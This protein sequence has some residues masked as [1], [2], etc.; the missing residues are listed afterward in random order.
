MTFKRIILFL[1]I[2]I[3]FSCNKNG[4]ILPENTGKQNEVILVIEDKL[5]GGNKGKILKEVFEKE[6]EGIY[7][8]E[9]LFKLIQINSK[10]FSRF[11]KTHKNIIFVSSYKKDSYDKNKWAK[12]QTVVYLNSDSEETDF[13]KSCQETFNFL[14]RKEIEQIKNNYKK[15]YNENASLYIK[16]EFGFEIFLPTE[17]TISL[18]KEGLFVADF[19]SFNE[20]QDLLKYIIV[21]DFEP[22]DYELQEEIVIKTDSVLK[23]YILGSIEG[24]YAQI[25]SKIPLIEDNGIYKGLWFL[26]NG[27]MG[28]PIIIKT[29][30]VEDKI[31]VSLG[32]IFHP[33]ENKRNFVRT[34]EAIL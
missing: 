19:H 26:K 22:T 7:Q 32:I 18:K 1:L 14:D 27:F 2:I 17:Y 23:Q 12:D 20:K 33:N 10:E 16:E 29:R 28:G 5:W 24:S 8:S 4:K 30:H 21:Y 25:E 34:F 3:L 6:I 31:V 15:G 13:R 9:K 11:F